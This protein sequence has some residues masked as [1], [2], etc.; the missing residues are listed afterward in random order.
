[1]TT[2]NMLL[3]H[4]GDWYDS[5]TETTWKS[6]WPHRGVPEAIAARMVSAF[7]GA[8]LPAIL[9]AF[10]D[11]DGPPPELR[12]TATHIQ[13]R[14]EG[15]ETW[16]DLVAL[17]DLKGEPG[18][19][20]QLQK[21]A[22]HIQWRY[23]GEAGWTDLVLLEDLRGDPGREVQLQ[24]SATH[25]QWRYEGEATWNNLVPLEELV[26]EAGADAQ[27]LELRVEGTNIEWRRGTGAWQ[28]LVALAA[29]KGDPGDEVELRVEG[30]NIEWRLTG[31]T[32]QTLIA[33]AA[34]KG[35]P[36]DQISLQVTATHIQ[37]RLGTGSWTNLIALSELI[38]PDGLSA[39]QVAVANGFVGDATA[40]LLSLVGPQGS[41][42]DAWAGSWDSGTAYT[43]GQVVEDDGASWIAET[44]NTNSKPAANPSDWS[45]FAAAGAGAVESVN[46]K[47]GVVTIAIEDID[48]L[49]AALDGKVAL[50]G[51]QNIA[52]HKRFARPAFASEIN[53]NIDINGGELFP[54]LYTGDDIFQFRTPVDV[55]YWNGSAWVAWS[56]GVNVA[57]TLLDGT[58]SPASIPTDRA[59]FRFTFAAIAWTVGLQ[60]HVYKQG[61][62][63][64]SPMAVK[65]EAATNQA[66]T[67]TPVEILNFT[68][69]GAGG[70]HALR[71]TDHHG[72]QNWYRIEI[73]FGS[74]S[75][76]QSVNLIA[77]RSN[78]SRGEVRAYKG[79]PW[80]WN[81]D[82][83]TT[84]LRVVLPAAYPDGRAP[85]RMPPVA[86]HP[87]TLVD[88]DL[89]NRDGQG[90][91]FRFGGVT[92]YFWG[93]HNAGVAS[94]AVAEAGTSTQLNIWTALRVRQAADAAITA[95]AGQKV[96]TANATLT[97]AESPPGTL[98][99]VEA[100]A[101][102][103]SRVTLTIPNSIPKGW[104][105]SFVVADGTLAFGLGTNTLEGL[106]PGNT[107]IVSAG[108]RCTLWARA[109]GTL[110][111][112]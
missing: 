110:V 69:A 100:E 49:Q 108:N 85:F 31:G 26:G 53:A 78:Y 60:F 42:A 3:W 43:I 65:I 90:P 63:V 73:D 96:F 104:R 76:A 14:V 46:G 13:W 6:P 64:M 70:Y 12:A 25:I 33:L 23:E 92:H 79:S 99:V 98:V 20:V 32:W 91:H 84:P 29:L 93:S 22:T 105:R 109:N 11:Y 40:W 58:A 36:G 89:W 50:S 67:G 9:D 8:E 101:A 68:M 44:D 52:G 27:E 95:R 41:L 83:V 5:V 88:G 59:R 47:S 55:Q 62:S 35:D 4:Q 86:N 102:T 1:M 30:T 72:P 45:L 77:A 38:G 71:H 75:V 61:V 28:T 106:S 37:W 111:R 81:R 94:Q 18:R 7:A 16:L 10:G 87:A 66:M 80:F 57:R 39:Y 17:D 97:D 48:D 15:S 19:E 51:D 24:K 34:L 112:I 82:E 54:T 21:S 2:R 56:E 103:D 74:P 107:P